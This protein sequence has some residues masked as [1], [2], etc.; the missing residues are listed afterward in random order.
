MAPFVID[1][2]HNLKK[3]LNFRIFVCLYYLDVDL[4]NILSKCINRIEISFR[5]KVIYYVSNK[6]RDSPTWFID[7]N[8]LNS[9]F[10]KDI[11]KYYN[12]SFILKT[13]Q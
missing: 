5:T 7:G 12:D 6:Y 2:K 8:V 4:R 9:N 11:D 1:D 10:I 13:S 3:T